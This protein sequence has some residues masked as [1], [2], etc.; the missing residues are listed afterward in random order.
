MRAGVLP[1]RGGGVGI[2]AGGGAEVHSDR[3]HVLRVGD[4]AL[5]AGNVH[6]HPGGEEEEGGAEAQAAGPVPAE[7]PEALGEEHLGGEIAHDA[8]DQ[9][10]RQEEPDALGEDGEELIEEDAPGQGAAEAH[11]VLEHGPHPGHG[12]HVP[13]ALQLA[14]AVEEQGQDQQ[15]HP[16][17]GEHQGGPQPLEGEALE[18]PRLVIEEAHPALGELYRRAQPG[19]EGVEAVEGGIAEDEEAQHRVQQRRHPRW[20]GS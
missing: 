1:G 8:R 2:V 19:R 13:G 20:P 16:G 15:D 11:A 10:Q 14:A 4:P 6:L 12:H 3:G 9:G 17:K 18:V 5:V 7:H